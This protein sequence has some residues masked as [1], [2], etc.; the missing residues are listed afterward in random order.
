MKFDR[1]SRTAEGHTADDV[2]VHRFVRH[3]HTS[4][5]RAA[6]T[7]GPRT[8]TY[9]QLLDSAVALASELADH[10]VT[11]GTLV[12]LTG[13]ASIELVVGIVAIHLLGAAYVP[14][15]PANPDDRLSS[16]AS[17]A[18]LQIIADAGGGWNP[19]SAHIIDIRAVCSTTQ[20][21]KGE[22]QWRPRA[23][24]SDLAYVLYTSGST[25]KPKGVLITQENIGRL[26]TQLLPILEASHQDVWTWF[27]SFGFDFSV[28][29]IWGALTSGGKIVVVPS[30]IGRNPSEF[31]T[32]IQNQRV[33]ILSQT[34][35]AFASL[36][37]VATQRGN[38]LRDL[39]VVVFGGERLDYSSL[40]PWVEHYPLGAPRLLNMYG[41]T[42][43][44]V[45]VTY[46]EVGASDLRG[47]RTIGKPLPDMELAITDQDG[48]TVP[49]GG[50]GEIRV[51]GP[52]VALGYLKRPDLTAERFVAD[53]SVAGK[54]W[55]R[56]GD[57]GQERP[58]GTVDYLG[59]S[60]NQVKIRGYRIELGEIEAAVSLHDQV[61]A[62]CAVIG[63]TPDRRDCITLYFTTTEGA[64]VPKRI[65]HDFAKNRL[66]QYMI[67]QVWHRLE[68]LPLTT[69]GKVDRTFLTLAARKVARL[70]TEGT[71]Q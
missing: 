65:L 71:E 35:S 7:D 70:S 53:Q 42:E 2:P 58:D 4:P 57:V 19:R 67:P 48:R 39:R 38:E 37:S 40:V 23:T 8:F 16:I 10:E 66:P 50:I 22:T 44:S 15:D 54:R 6:V 46:Y 11:R 55:Y 60:D 36:C 24:K 25:G 1:K 34:P 21:Q 69:N 52:G 33:S 45:H 64:D 5:S 9:D 41:I 30:E 29:E 20:S 62:A 59:R 18:D 32:L 51:A 28:W 49:V 63:A 31:A 13:R 27:H 26:F 17:E 3:A 43:G 12:G 68:A 56:S 14:L 47:S 61:S